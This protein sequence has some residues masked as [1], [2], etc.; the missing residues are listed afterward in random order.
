V[1]RINLIRPEHLTKRHLVAEYKEITQFLHIV[2][3]RVN[4]QH[5]MDDLPKKYT[6]NTGHCKFFFDKGKYIHDRMEYLRDEML[7]RSITVDDD[8]FY[9]RLQRVVDSYS[10]V[11]YN[12]YVPSKEDYSI[13]IARID[14][15]IKEKPELYT[16]ADIFYRG[17]K[18]YE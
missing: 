16:D 14:Q 1:T 8:N 17:I 4:E 5:P 2:R 6:L 15:R 3:K 13:V 10:E 9:A 11:L 12:D 7:A 18:E